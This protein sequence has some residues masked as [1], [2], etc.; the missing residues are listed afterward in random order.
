MNENDNHIVDEG[1]LVKYLLG[2]AGPQERQ[3]VEAWIEADPAHRRQ[4]ED[5]A[6][7]WEK[8]RRLALQS[9]ADEQAAWKRFQ[10][11]IHTAP[12]PV[13]SLRNN[14]WLR[15]AALFLLLA[16]VGTWA[17]LSSRETPVPQLTA[18][19]G[20]RIL[21]DTLPD[22]S[23]VTLNRNAS[24]QYPGRF[25]G[26]TRTVRL[27]GEAFFRVTPDKKKPFLINVN[28]VMVKVVG[29]SF[30]IR[31]EGKATEV[32]VET[33]IVQVTRNGHTV[34]LRPG[35]KVRVGDQ[36]SLFAPQPEKDRLYNYYRTNEFVCDNTPLWKLAEVLQEAYGVEI[37]IARK[38]LRNLPLTTTF[39]N[40]SLDRILEVIGMTFNI[41]VKKEG[42]KIY[43]L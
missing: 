39:S 40:E 3:A 32:I 28:D 18:S 7:I 23:V 20:A 43:L 17:W 33:G 1:L 27:Q 25:Q 5:F 22:G 9:Q 21:S 37:V 24:L 10:A 15:I 4:F 26:D 19:A 14:T 30:N 38:E 34:E 29:T 42:D 41:R 16:G 2:E 35:Q 36:D 13:R 31:S 6:S 12:R 11:R 8:S